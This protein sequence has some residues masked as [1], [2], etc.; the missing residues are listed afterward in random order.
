MAS[1]ALCGERRRL[2][3]RARELSFVADMMI[4]GEQ[5]YRGFR[6]RARRCAA[7]AAEC[8]E[9]CRD[10]P[11]AKSRCLRA[12]DGAALSTSV[13]AVQRRRRTRDVAARP[14]RRAPA[15]R[16]ART[17]R[18][19][20]SRTV[21]ERRGR[22]R[23]SSANAAGCLR[24]RPAPKPRLLFL[25]FIVRCPVELRVGPAF[26]PA[27]VDET[28]TGQRPVWHRI[29][30]AESHAHLANCS[31]IHNAARRTGRSAAHRRP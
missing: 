17:A 13:D 19:A 27:A 29:V 1:A 16:A 18:R 12:D 26:P 6:D 24:R 11:V 21:L 20:V 9:P 2:A 31:Q 23:S 15:P 5:Q 4:G 10:S 3:Q 8:R 22:S 25:R 30:P 28:G 14:P 7:A